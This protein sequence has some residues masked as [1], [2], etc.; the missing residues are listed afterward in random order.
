[1]TRE[2]YD[3]IN[4][5]LLEFIPDDARSIVEIGCG[6]GAVGRAFK[7][8]HPEA[9]YVGVELEPEVA[10]IAATRLDAAIAANVEHLDDPKLQFAPES[11]DCLVYGDVLEHLR[12]PWRV[13]RHHVSWLKPGGT[14]VASIPNVQNWTILRDLFQG[15]WEYKDE[16]L[17]DRTHLRFFT[18]ETMKAM[19]EDAGLQVLKVGRTLCHN[20][21]EF[22]RLY[23]HLEVVA[24]VLEQ[25][26]D[27]FKLLVETHQFV[28]LAHKPQRRLLIQTLM[29]APL[30]CDRV[31][32]LEPDEFNNRIPGVRA[33]SSEKN[34][35][36][37]IAE[38][39]EEKVFVWQRALLVPS[40]ALQ[41][42]KNLIHR[43]YLVVAE[44]DDDPM[45]WP[46]FEQ[47]NF[48]TYRSCHCVQTSTE[49]L[50]EFLRQFNPYV[51]VFPNHLAQLPPPRPATDYEVMTVFFGAL[52]R[53]EDWQG[54]L[55]P[56]NRVLGEFGDRVTVKVLHD[57]KFFDALTVTKKV[58]S[59]FCSYEIYQKVIRSS[60][61]ALLPLEPTRFNRMKSDL[62]F[63]ECGG[64]GVA[65]LASPTVYDGSIIDGKTGLIYRSVEDFEMKFRALLSR[66]E[67][68]RKL[69]QN[70]YQWVAEHR[71]L[72]RH[73]RD[74]V[75]WYFEMRD[76][77]PELN[78][79]LRERMPEL[80]DR[81]SN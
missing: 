3:R 28:V 9:K 39:D 49:P 8:K 48:F 45:R 20:P 1:M 76:R 24:K 73:A 51:K 63:L 4:P 17:L 67:L 15:Q 16:G 62:K 19:F 61:V 53:E 65:V 70:A 36:L 50:A 35:V 5:Q 44:I 11:L 25:P 81:S 46:Q 30:A 6:T 52:N 77:L 56:M 42:Q 37:S 14:I 74:R 21:K 60:T 22:D 13:V 23:P 78:E 7:E 58:F 55:E 57:R 43:G 27:R 40:V 34:A 12:D 69:G 71:L 75:N 64:Q 33:V 2:Y 79:S 72:E 38:P 41:Q 54:I 31:R 66:A 80:F 47:T 29:M 10:N 18:L 59:P 26:L 32:V 68:R